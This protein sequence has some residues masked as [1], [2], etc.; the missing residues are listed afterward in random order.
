LALDEQKLLGLAVVVV[1]ATRNARVRREV[2]A[3]HQT[4]VA[5][6]DDG[7]V[8]GGYGLKKRKIVQHER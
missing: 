6:S 3:C 5:S 1:P 4:D 8:H 2:A 7:V